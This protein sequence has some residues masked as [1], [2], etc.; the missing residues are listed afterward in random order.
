MR[1]KNSPQGKS[2]ADAP[3]RAER[4]QAGRRSAGT[5][6]HH[7]NLRVALMQAAEQLA[8]DKGLEGFS[9]REC[10]KMAGVSPAAPA[11]HFGSSSGLLEAV[12]AAGFDELS[13]RMQDATQG[14]EGSPPEQRLTAMAH[15]YLEFA[16]TRV[17]SFKITFRGTFA[18]SETANTGL[19]AAS[20]RAFG[21]LVAEVAKLPASTATPDSVLPRALFV[22][23]FV[24]GFANLL[25][26]R[27]MTF[28]TKNGGAP[29]VDAL[30]AS[31]LAEFDSRMA[32]R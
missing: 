15:A 3:D 21:L 17:G 25:I 29:G 10:A 2:A 5:A 4:R 13:A 11:Y 18:P 28:L 20:E 19:I 32:A 27:R 22:W 6:Y 7:G 9:L 24:H 26:D 23:S 12:A 31:V 16:R 1:V 14:L 8:A 30:I